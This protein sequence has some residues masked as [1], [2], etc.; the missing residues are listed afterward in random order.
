MDG[1]DGCVEGQQNNLCKATLL[2]EKPCKCTFPTTKLSSL[3]S[4]DP[5][6]LISISG[7][8]KKQSKAQ[9]KNAFFFCFFHFPIFPFFPFLCATRFPKKAGEIYSWS[10]LTTLRVG[11]L[12][13]S[14]TA[15][16]RVMCRCS[17]GAQKLDVPLAETAAGWLW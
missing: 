10:L 2:I 4:F 6:F 11:T 14:R 8:K 5:L 13:L 15:S 1:I 16:R 12:Q 9:N 7:E 17:W 3:L